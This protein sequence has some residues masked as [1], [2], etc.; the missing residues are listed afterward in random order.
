MDDFTTAVGDTVD[1][2]ITAAGASSRVWFSTFAR[3]VD[4]AAQTSSTPL[5]ADSLAQ[6]MAVLTAAGARDVALAMQTWVAI[7]SAIAK[8]DLTGGGAGGGQGGPGGPP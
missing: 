1:K 6:D 4:G 5:T 3:L 7:G 2:A 8:L